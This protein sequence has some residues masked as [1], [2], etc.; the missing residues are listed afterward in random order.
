MTKRLDEEFC[1]EQFQKLLQ[2][3]LRYLPDRIYWE[4]VPPAHE[5]PDYYLWANG[6]RFAVEVTVV[7]KRLWAI[8]AG[9]QGIKGDQTGTGRW[10]A[11]S[12]ACVS[13]PQVPNL[14][15]GAE[16]RRNAP[17]RCQYGR[18]RAIGEIAG[19][20]TGVLGDAGASDR[21]C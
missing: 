5:P 4:E 6:W 3:K 19:G 9:R 17:I 16:G 1:R 21:A 10:Q 15:K 8:R 20:L 14:R 7:L 12:R 2:G 18:V 13:L 11:L